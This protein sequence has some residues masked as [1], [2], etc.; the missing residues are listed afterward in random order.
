MLRRGGCVGPSVSRVCGC[1]LRHSRRWVGAAGAGRHRW[2]RRAA[3]VGVAVSLSRCLAWAL[4]GGC[5]RRAGPGPGPSSSGW[6]ARR[7]RRR[8]R[9]VVASSCMMRSR[10]RCR[11]RRVGAGRGPGPSASGWRDRRRRRRRRV[12]ASRLKRSRCRCRVVRVG[13]RGS[14][15]G[16][17]AAALRGDCPRRACPCPACPVSVGHMGVG[18]RHPRASLSWRSSVASSWSVGSSGRAPRL[19]AVVRLP[20]SRSAVCAGRWVGDLRRVVWTVC[21]WYGGGSGS[22]CRRCLVVCSLS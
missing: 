8:R 16:C 9:R 20:G 18:L 13:V 11:V 5:P 2:R 14:L 1:H 12:V 15:S 22:W 6:R 19:V 7:R 10:W 21:R 3:C 4:R 17:P